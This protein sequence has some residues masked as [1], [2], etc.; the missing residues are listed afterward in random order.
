MTSSDISTTGDEAMPQTAAELDR[1]KET[2]VTACRVLAKEGLA[3]AAF[4]VSCRYQKDKILI[5]PVTSPTLVTKDNIKMISLDEDPE[6]GKVHPSIYKA[7]DDV[8]AVVH[9]HPPYSIAFSTIGEEFIPI[10]HYGCPFYG[11]PVYKSP[12]QVQNVERSRDAVEVLG[13]GPA[14]LQQGHGVIVVG[15][16]LREALL[17]TIYLEEA[18]K[19]NFL[20][21]LMGKPE[22]ISK[23]LAE[24]ITPQF[25]NPESQNKAWNHY[26]DKLN[27]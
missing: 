16:D 3:E 22:Q 25:M 9:V 5:I 20:A 24:K 13:D 11:L 27:G 7:R 19:I 18:M 1:L 15:K 17:L 14:V 6:V 12:G 2:F 23:E 21:T 8:N 10:H 26:V 4:N